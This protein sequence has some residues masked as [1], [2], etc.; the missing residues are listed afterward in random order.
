MQESESEVAQSGP[1]LSEPTDCSPPG[2][3]HGIFQARVLEW[4]ATAF[5][6]SESQVL[7]ISLCGLLH[8][9][10]CFFSK[11]SLSRWC[12]HDLYLFPPLS[13]ELLEGK[14]YIWVSVVFPVELSR[15][16]QR[17]PSYSFNQMQIEDVWRQGRNQTQGVVMWLPFFPPQLYFSVNC[18][19]FIACKKDMFLVVMVINNVSWIGLS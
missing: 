12:G 4:G 14:D 3:A 17:I 1:T 5:S 18:G 8:S 19:Y 9:C 16:I 2:S 10:L 13:H 11:V 7:L 15:H 6:T